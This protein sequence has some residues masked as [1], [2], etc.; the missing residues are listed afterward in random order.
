MCCSV[1]QCVAVMCIKQRS[2]P[3]L[4]VHLCL[5]VSICICMNIYMLQSVA[6]CCSVLQ[7][8][9][10]NIDLR[11]TSGAPLPVYIYMY[12]YEC[13]YVAECCSV[14]QC[15]SVMCIKQRFTPHLPV[16]CWLCYAYVQVYVYVSI[17]ICICTCMNVWMY[18]CCS[19]LQFSTQCCSD[20]HQTAIHATQRCT[21]A[22]V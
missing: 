11:R 8:S 10:S 19:V 18:I 12:M 21:V 15:V 1:L 6:V 22:F 3:H 5:C 14:L 13:I 20:V 2:T 4:M 17:C 9:A 7:W 16:H